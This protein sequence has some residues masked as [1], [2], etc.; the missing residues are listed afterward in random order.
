[1][2]AYH[3]REQDKTQTL[4][5]KRYL[6]IVKQNKHVITLEK[7]TKGELSGVPYYVLHFTPYVEEY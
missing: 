7:G 5:N 2:P 3:K 6:F 1:M 4:Q